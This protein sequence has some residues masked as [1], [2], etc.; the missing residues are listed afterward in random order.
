[1]DRGGSVGPSNFR[2]GRDGAWLVRSRQI[3]RTWIVGGTGGYGSLFSP[4]TQGGF[5]LIAVDSTVQVLRSVV[6]SGIGGGG[7]R[8]VALRVA[9]A[10]RLVAAAT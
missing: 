8:A 4:S 3:E 7:S 5:G 2:I 6:V 10:S 1:L 9:T